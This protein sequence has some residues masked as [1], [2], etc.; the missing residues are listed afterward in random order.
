MK[1]I[2]FKKGFEKIGFRTPRWHR[3]KQSMRNFV[4][5]SLKRKKIKENALQKMLEKQQEQEEGV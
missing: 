3:V 5:H 4:K 2:N 1:Q